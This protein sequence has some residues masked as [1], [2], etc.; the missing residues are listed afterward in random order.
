VSELLPF[1]PLM[2]MIILILITM[3]ISHYLPRITTA[4]PATLTAI[5]FVT[6]LGKL[7]PPLTGINVYT[8]LDFIQRMDPTK[9]TVAITLPK[10]ILPIF[11][12]DAVLTVLPYAIL[13]ATVGLIE[14]LL[15]LVLVDELTQTRGRGNKESIG[16]GIANLI[17]G[18]FGGMGGCAMIGQSMIN[19][20]AGGRGRFS[21]I[22][23]A[24]F[25]LVFA[26]FGAVFIESIPLAA[27]VGV[28]FM[29]SI[30]TFEW[31]SF[32]LFRQIPLSDFLVIIVVSLTTVFVDLAIAVIVGVIISALVFAWEQGKKIHVSIISDDDS[33]CRYVLTGGLFFGSATLFKGLFNFATDPDHVYID[34]KGARVY[35][36]SG[37]EAIRFVANA[38]RQNNKKL[39]LLNVSK[40]CRDLLYAAD[41]IVEVS[42]IE[43]LNWHLADDR[44]A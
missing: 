32:R 36:H 22:V 26:V 38:Y 16:Q 10:F 30:G 44:L 2:I 23:A 6:V 34:F 18:F 11:T 33:S 31:T 39:H 43:N 37:I 7:I 20:R 24:V 4:I 14:S 42:I 41:N 40:E 1:L 27:L 21:G 8:V 29:V 28:M 35:D 3:G 13:A 5:I 25:L 17:N 15:T 19:I 9:T 12:L